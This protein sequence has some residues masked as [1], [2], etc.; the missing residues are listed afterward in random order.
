MTAAKPVVVLTMGDPA[1]VGP[2]VALR[3]IADRA[4]RRAV[5]PLLV[6]DPGVFRE[7]A[8]RLRMRLAAPVVEVS[9]LRAR[10]RRPGKPTAEG[11]TAAYRAI[12]EGVRLVRQ[13][14]ASAIVTAPVS[15]AAIRDLGIEFSGH[16]ELIAR[17]AGNAE[18]RMM[19]A[20]PRLRVV[21]VTTHI[22]YAAVPEALTAPRIVRTAEIAAGAL[23]RDFG[24]KRPRL[25]LAGLNPHAGERGMLGDDEI[26]LLEPAAA[27]VRRKGLRLEGPLPADTVFHRAVEGEFDA[28]LALYHDQG[29]GPFKVLHFRDGVNV[30]IGLPFPRTS[31]DHGTAYDRAGKKSVDPTSMIAATLLAAGMSGTG[32]G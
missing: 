12:V 7:T 26:R 28:V 15:K 32:R 10:E 19:M 8:R 29:L 24:V 18:V 31:P 11:A 5:E 16:T 23:Q 30:T 25:A 20:G 13:K 4:V 3:A 22:P 14:T 1:G 2:E 6:G 21:L 17:L 9:E 27:K